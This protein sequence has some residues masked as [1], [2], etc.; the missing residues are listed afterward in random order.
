MIYESTDEEFLDML[1][2]LNPTGFTKLDT[3]LVKRIY[4]FL[5]KPKHVGAMIHASEDVD[6]STGK[7]RPALE[8]VGAK[9]K[10]KFPDC[11][12]ESAGLLSEDEVK[13]VKNFQ[14]RIGQ[15]VKRVLLQYDYVDIKDGAERGRIN[16]LNNPFRSG[17]V[18]HY[19]QGEAKKERDKHAE[20]VKKQKEEGK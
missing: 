3:I 12:W 6:P 8:A 15:I 11:H 20:M 2:S 10:E 9:L 19:H 13:K 16:D 5:L 7:G 18:Y 4:D 14:T 1:G 17:A